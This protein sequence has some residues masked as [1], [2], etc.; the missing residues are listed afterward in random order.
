MAKLFGEMEDERGIE[1]H[2]VAD[3]QIC[4]NFYYGSREQSVRALKVCATVRPAIGATF[5]T[6]TVTADFVSPRGEVIHSH[7]EE[8]LMPMRSVLLREATI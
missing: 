4:A 1:V 2:K 7:K 6:V 5:E 3:R 8:Y